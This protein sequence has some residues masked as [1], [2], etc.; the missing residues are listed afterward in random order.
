MTVQAIPSRKREVTRAAIA[1]TI[2]I[3]IVAAIGLLVSHMF[4]IDHFDRVYGFSFGTN[5]HY[6]YLDLDQWHALVW[7]CESAR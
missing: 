1:L 5:S 4:T 6:C 3:L 2:E 7:G